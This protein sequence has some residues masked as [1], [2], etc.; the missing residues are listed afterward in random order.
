MPQLLNESQA[1]YNR[2]NP[3]SSRNNAQMDEELTNLIIKEL[4]KHRDRKEIARIICEHSNLNWSEAERRIEEVEAQNRQK[5]A[6][7]QS[8]FLIF[9]SIGT[10]IL[11][12]GLLAYNIEFMIRF[13]NTDTL[14]QILS[15]RSGYYRVASLIT[16]LGMTVGGFYG[17]WKTL[18]S[19]FPD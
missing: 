5:I 9:V 12:I 3:K 16:G 14:G 2:Q 7:R 15:L 10:L 1:V 18:A 6:A 19:L 11:G 8:P 17:V 4:S 13:F